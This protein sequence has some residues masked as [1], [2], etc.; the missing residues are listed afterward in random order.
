MSVPPAMVPLMGT[1]LVTIG[2]Q[3]TTERELTPAQATGIACVGCRACGVQL[4]PVGVAVPPRGPGI[5]T[6]C[7]ACGPALLAAAA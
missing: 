1:Y 7:A 5:V 3:A 6:A 4:I 2:W